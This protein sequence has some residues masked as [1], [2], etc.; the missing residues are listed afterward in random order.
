MVGPNARRMRR[1]ELWQERGRAAPHLLERSAELV[2]VDGGLAIG[3]RMQ[4]ERIDLL[5]ASARPKLVAREAGETRAIDEELRLCDAQREEIGHVVVVDGVPVSH[6]LDVAVDAA[7]AIGDARRVVRMFRQ[8]EQM[9]R[10]VA[11]PI[12]GRLP[13][14]FADVDNALEPI[15]KLRCEVVAVSKGAAVEERALVLP[16][17]PLDTRFGIGFPA[18]RGRLDSVVCRE[19]EIPWIV[20]GLMPFPPEHDGFLAVVLASGSASAEA[21]E[22]A[23]VAVHQGEEI[24]GAEDSEVLSLR[25][26]QDVREQLHGLG[27]TISVRQHVRRP[28]VFGHLARPEHGGFEA[29]RR[30]GRRSH[31]PEVFLDAGV[32]PL[33]S[34]LLDDLEHALRGDVGVAPEKLAH[35]DAIR[36]D[37]RL[38]GRAR[39]RR[40]KGRVPGVA[41]ATASPKD[42]LDGVST[43]AERAGDRAPAHPLRRQDNDLMDQL[44]A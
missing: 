13:V 1:G 38:A 17:A 11:K 27:A 41:L 7:E 31:T 21:R 30:L 22:R 3:T 43:D 10:L 44:L 12:E 4:T 33:E 25:V 32:S 23:L 39:G 24:R 34:L 28:V 20:D 19:G 42:L 18:H 15:G 36:V 2:D 26:D 16:E 29:R 8:R 6:P 9:G 35:A 40:S 5:A 37:L 14:T